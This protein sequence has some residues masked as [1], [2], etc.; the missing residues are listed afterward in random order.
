MVVPED[1]AIGSQALL[2]FEVKGLKS[3]MVKGDLKHSS[4]LHDFWNMGNQK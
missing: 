1:W 3:S 4:Y 2:G